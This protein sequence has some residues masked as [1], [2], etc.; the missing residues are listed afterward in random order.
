MLWN[1]FIIRHIEVPND[2]AVFRSLC[3]SNSPGDSYNAPIWTS[4]KVN[5]DVNLDPPETNIFSIFD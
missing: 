5:F 1:Q 3:R 2:F 4:R